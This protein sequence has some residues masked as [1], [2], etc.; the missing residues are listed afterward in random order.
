M[1][2]VRVV[3]D[4]SALIDYATME[5]TCLAVGE[6]IQTIGEDNGSSLVGVPVSGL[7][8]ANLAVDGAGRRR[9]IELFAGGEG[10]IVSLPLRGE[11]LDDIV[12]LVDRMS[13]ARHRDPWVSLVPVAQAVLETLR[14]DAS[15]ATAVAAELR[16]YLHDD[17]VDDLTQAWD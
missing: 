11:D 16:M 8:A 14:H 12:A 2:R 17:Q 15:L 9:L 6:L 7:L 3:L 1:S 5:G 13:H 10:V 4:G